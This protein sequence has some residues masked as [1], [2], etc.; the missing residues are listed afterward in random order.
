[1]GNGAKVPQRQA[2][3]VAFDVDEFWH[4]PKRPQQGE[5]AQA[6]SRQPVRQVPVRLHQ[7]LA[8][9]FTEEGYTRERQ[10]ISR[11]CPPRNTSIS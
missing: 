8:Q 6:R 11:R 1:M 3:G 10:G 9:H 4:D 7:A 5:R 2:A